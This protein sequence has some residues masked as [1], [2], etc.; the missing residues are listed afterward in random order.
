DDLKGGVASLIIVDTQ[1]VPPSLPQLGRSPTMSAAQPDTSRPRG[2]GAWL[3]AAGVLAGVLS[4]QGGEVARRA[5]RSALEPKIVPR[6]TPEDQARVIRGLTTAA[7][8]VFVQQGA[9]LGAVLGL[10][11]GLGRRSAPAALGAGVA[12]AVLGAAAGA[13]G[14]LAMLS[15]YY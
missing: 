4:W 9:I 14:A 5:V 7:T 1:Y 10:V 11:G 8:V 13:G 6:P 2:N 12:G 3:L 15:V